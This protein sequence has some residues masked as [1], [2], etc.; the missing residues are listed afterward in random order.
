MYSYVA[1]VP[2]TNLLLVA[3]KLR[4]EGGQESQCYKAACTAHQD[5]LNPS[6]R[7]DLVYN[8]SDKIFTPHGCKS[9]A[10]LRRA[11]SLCYP[12]SNK[13]ESNK[14]C[15]SGPPLASLPCLASLLLFAFLSALPL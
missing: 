13:T 1:P 10:R 8:A 12:R 11:P 9:E 14:E 7:F 5:P 6:I 15:S 4:K 2:T 3:F